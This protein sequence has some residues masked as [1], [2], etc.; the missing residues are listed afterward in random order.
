VIV[1]GVD[2]VALQAHGAVID[3]DWST[4]RLLLHPYRR[5]TDADGVTVRGCAR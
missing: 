2:E 4:L 5:W 3:Q 1:T